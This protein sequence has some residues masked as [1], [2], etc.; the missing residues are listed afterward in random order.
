MANQHPDGQNTPPAPPGFNLWGMLGQL[1]LPNP[2]AVLQELQRLNAN[3]EHLAP[4]LDLLAQVPKDLH[5]LVE[6]LKK[7]DPQQVQELT[8]ALKQ[9]SETGEKFAGRLW[10][11]N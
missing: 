5:E 2:D 3:L 6:G 4:G 9:A 11:E 1:G 7:L 8:A 10:P